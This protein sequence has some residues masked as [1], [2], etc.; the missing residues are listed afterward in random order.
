MIKDQSDYPATSA[1]LTISL[2]FNCVKHKRHR[3][4]TTATNVR[5]S[6]AQETP[7]PMYLG[8]MIHASCAL[9]VCPVRRYCH[10]TVP[11]G[12]GSLPS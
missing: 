10:L 5:H 8:L 12:T 2:K 11:P 4:L 6:T 9:F 7:L 1:A 3:G